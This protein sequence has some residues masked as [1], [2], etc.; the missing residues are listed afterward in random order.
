M[1]DFVKVLGR[2]IM[3]HFE[4]GNEK[5]TRRPLKKGDVKHNLSSQTSSYKKSLLA[6]MF[7]LLEC[8]PL[9]DLPWDYALFPFFSSSTVKGPMLQLEQLPKV[10]SDMP[11]APRT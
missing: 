10:F 5:A 2:L 3:G 9:G 1:G 6:V 8:G 4:K 11:P 7:S